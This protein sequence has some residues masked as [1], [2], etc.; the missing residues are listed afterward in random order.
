[1]FLSQTQPRMVSIIKYGVLIIVCL[2]FIP[3]SITRYATLV[4]QHYLNSPNSLLLH[5]AVKLRQPQALLQHYS[6]HAQWSMAQKNRWLAQPALEGNVEADYLKGFNRYH[7]G[8]MATARLWLKSAWQK[9]HIKGALLYGQLLSETGE[10]QQATHVLSSALLLHNGQARIQLAQLMLQDNKM[11]QASALLAELTML[12]VSGAKTLL[13]KVERLLNL[14]FSII[15][16]ESQQCLLTLQMM[17]AGYA[18]LHYA[19]ELIERWHKD[20][21][22]AEMPVCFSRPLLFEPQQFA[23][24]ALG[25]NR[26]QC[27]LTLMA[28]KLEIA[29]DVMPVLIYG[30]A[31]MANYNNGIVYLNRHKGYKI[32]K[33][34]LFHHF[35]FIDEYALPKAVAGRICRPGLVGENLFVVKAGEVA[36][37]PSSWR[38]TYADSGQ[39]MTAVSSCEGTRY[40]AYR[41][42]EKMTLMEFMDQPLP[43]SYI[44]SASEKLRAQPFELANY[45]Y[46]Y[47]LAFDDKGDK[48]GYRYWLEQSAKQGY[49]V[50]QALLQ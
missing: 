36:R 35:G 18:E 25:D 12:Q 26:Q 20:A 9:G 22:M 17:V 15:G 32:F 46:A 43:T 34:E 45:Q 47:A 24:D 39:A 2:L 10:Y 5:Q 19:A 42:G 44:Q 13:S 31:G 48:V 27:N 7:S 1:M 38:K 4:N 3:S 50:A 14:P 41:P 28:Q 8:Q 40:I 23:C 33:H 30:D 6:N 21:L 11:K 37:M 49:R 29:D 16:E